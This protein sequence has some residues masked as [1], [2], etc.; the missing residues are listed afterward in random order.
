MSK[1]LKTS[2]EGRKCLFPDCTH[3]LSIYNHDAYCH[4]HRE[5]MAEEKKP[6]ILQAIP[7][8]VGI[9]VVG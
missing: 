7:L 8:V 4:L 3:T 6:K 1:S 2:A 5:Q 9:H